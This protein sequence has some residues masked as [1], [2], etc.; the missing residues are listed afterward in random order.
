MPIGSSCRHEFVSTGSAPP[1]ARFAFWRD[2]C[3]R[4]IEPYRSAH[5]DGKPFNASVR[6]LISPEG[7]FADFRAA[8]SGVERTPR[9]CR[10]DGI[11]NIVVSLALSRGGGGWFGNPDAATKL[12]TG[13]IRVRDEGRPYVV[14]WAGFDHHTLHVDVPRT[15]FPSPT[16]DRVLAAN[17]AL[18]PPEGLAP[19]LAAQMRSLAEVAG[20]LDPTARLA[21]LHAVV[22]LAATVL[23]L[24]F[25]SE[26][27]DSATCEDGMLIAAQAFIRRHFGSTEL[28]PDNIARRLSCSRAHLYR[29]FARNGLTI[30]GYL[31][32]VRLQNCRTTLA[33]AGSREP[34]ADIAFRCG[35]TNPVYFARL[36]RERFGLRPSE[37]RALAAES[38]SDQL[39]RTS[40]PQ[41]I[42]KAESP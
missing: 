42:E 23:R 12:A 41:P 13:F 34:V 15:R 26:P 7:R 32:E 11:D 22:E 17:G 9:L 24:S 19:M 8:S 36:F 5:V 40:H 30:A 6:E 3:L 39:T 16:L 1:D 28:T 33:A 20:E 10:S 2:S 38:A 37:L 21:G 27:G 14:Q 18:L 4:R 29:V 35:F 31:R 25:G